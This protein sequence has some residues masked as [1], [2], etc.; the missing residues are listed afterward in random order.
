M[1]EKPKLV[2]IEGGKRDNELIDPKANGGTEIQARRVFSEFPDLVDKFNWV[3]SYPKIDLDPNKP[4]LLW[5][6]ETPFDQGIQQQFQKPDYWKQYT[7]I[8]FVSYW[9]QQMFHI[10]YGVPYENSIV[11]QNSIDPI[12]VSEKPKIDKNNPIKLIYASSPN[13]GLDILL[14]VVESE[15]FKDIDFELSVYSSFKLYNRKSNDIQFENLFDRC[16]KHEK[17]KYYGTRSNEE[18]KEA[19]SNSHIMTYPNS[20]AET[21]CITAMEAMSGGCLIVCPKYGAL[22]ETTS[23]FS[24]SYNFE[25]DKM[26]H[27]TIFK[28]V[29]MEAIKNYDQNNV[30]Q[31]LKLQK[32]FCDTF[33]HWNTKLSI[34][35]Q[36]LTALHS[37]YNEDPQM[38]TPEAV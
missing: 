26:R 16:K 19:M 21:S 31:M 36:M 35:E 5:M 7:K 8:I 27:E 4:S 32:V 23:E 24:W 38:P 29:L 9:Q 1:S 6:H 12:L 25:S 15:E 22:P 11:I 14:N 28:Y 10:L 13:R 37:Q 33:Y 2:V 3:L 18:I 17:I 34:W 20:Y 30:K